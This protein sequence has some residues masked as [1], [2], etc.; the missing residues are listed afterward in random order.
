MKFRHL[1]LPLIASLAL[2]SACSKQDATGTPTSA[3]DT[4][5]IPAAQALEVLAAQGKGF[6]A[7]TLMSA[8]AVYVLFDAQCPHC[9]HLWESS[10]PLQSKVKFVW[11]PVSLLNA[12]SAPQGA[13]IMTAANPVEAMT[14]HEKSLLAGQGGTAASASIAPEVEAAIKANTA[15]LDRLG[16][17]SVPF[18]VAKNLRTG[19]VVTNAGSLDTEPL[20]KLLGLGQP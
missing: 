2:L 19:A 15:L 8:N 7:G 14:A 20:A 10:L 3:A 1:A 12:K 18:V 6:T 11:L 9:G 4:A 13:A 17:T 5:P 16:A